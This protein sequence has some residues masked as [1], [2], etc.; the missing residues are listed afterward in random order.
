[1]WRD[2]D[3]RYCKNWKARLF[4]FH[5]FGGET[6]HWC[7]SRKSSEVHHARYLDEAGNQIAGREFLG[8]DIF[9]VCDRCHDK[10]NP[11]GVHGRKYWV[12][13]LGDRNRNTPEAIA[14]LKKG[15]AK[16]ALKVKRSK[17]KPTWT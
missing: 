1:M 3:H 10:G 13:G 6:C 14:R 12:T 2:Y 9:L 4:A 8:I 5:V 15:Y 16:C 11:E 17:R 7:C